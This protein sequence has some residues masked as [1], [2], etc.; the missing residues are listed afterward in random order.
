MS[1]LYNSAYT[2]DD[3]AD[4]KIAGNMC[5]QLTD[6]KICRFPE[7]TCLSNS[8]TMKQEYETEHNVWY[9]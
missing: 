8:S 3:G 6:L 1:L 4:P 2:N 9:C 7:A 5:K